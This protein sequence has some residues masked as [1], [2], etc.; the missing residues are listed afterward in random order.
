MGICMLLS[1]SFA[2][3]GRLGVML[4]LLSVLFWMSRTAEKR[5]EF[6]EALSWA[7]HLSFALAFFSW[8]EWLRTS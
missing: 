5:Q 7:V 4:M 3:W 6:N 2:C 8:E 1:A